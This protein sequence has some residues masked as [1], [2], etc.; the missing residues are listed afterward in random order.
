MV[1]MHLPRCVFL[2]LALLAAHTSTGSAQEHAHSESPSAIRWGASAQAI[3]LLTHAAP[4]IGGKSYTEGYLTQPNLMDHLGLWDERVELSGTLNLEG[5]TL[6]RGELNA[7]I[8]GEGYIDRRHPHTYSHEVMGTMRLLGSSG[9]AG[10][11]SV[12]FGKGFVPFGSDDPMVRPF[13]KYPVN[14]HLAQI[15]ERLVGIAAVRYGPFLV[16]AALFNGDEPNHPADFATLDRFGDSWST[17]GTLLP[18]PGWEVSGSYA[19]VAS[20]EFPAGS[21]LDH[22][23]RSASVRYSAADDRYGQR[24]ALLEWARTDEY[25]VDQRAFSFTSILGEAAVSRGALGA[26]LRY[27]RTTRPEEE[28]LEDPFRSPRPHGDVHILGA[29]RWDILTAGVRRSVS[30]G[31][32]LRAEPFVEVSYAR[33]TETLGSPVFDPAEFYGSDRMWGLSAGVRMQVGAT[34]TRM[35]RYGAANLERLSGFGHHRR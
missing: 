15:L 25:V 19:S 2:M 17:R 10:E 14:H 13:V 35:G 28:R 7:G 26:T 5:V 23:K 34:H 6:R 9:A 16:E 24:Y 22:R 31:T 30:P 21:G 12:S 32:A 4:A 20:P 27:E 3:G 33:A 18:L 1:Q 8:W 29:T 11:V